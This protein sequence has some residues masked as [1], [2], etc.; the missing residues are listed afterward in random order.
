MPTGG[1]QLLQDY[2]RTLTTAQLNM[3]AA[4]IPLT[5]TGSPAGAEL[6]YYMF[7]TCVSQPSPL[8][9]GK[10]SWPS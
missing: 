8:C 3:Q 5:L 1:P 10:R 4:G 9:S 7:T 6:R 2:L